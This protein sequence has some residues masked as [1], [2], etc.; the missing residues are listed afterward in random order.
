MKSSRR[1]VSRITAGVTLIEL[2][3]VIAIIAVILFPVFAHV[4]E[5]AR[6]AACA[7][8]LGQIG[9]AAMQYFQDN[10]ERMFL[11]PQAGQSRG[12]VS[13]G[14]ACRRRLGQVIRR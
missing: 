12:S 8:N 2:V 11:I 14:I 10:D 3:V 6:Q 9:L 5:K 4:R 13:R 1:I 7:S